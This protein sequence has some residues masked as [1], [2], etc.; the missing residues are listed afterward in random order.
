MFPRRRRGNNTQPNW[1]LF[2][3]ISEIITFINIKYKDGRIKPLDTLYTTGIENEDG[4]VT[5]CCDLLKTPLD[6]SKIAAVMVGS[7]EAAVEQ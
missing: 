1:D 6:K 3:C 4:T 7:A 5:L 2:W